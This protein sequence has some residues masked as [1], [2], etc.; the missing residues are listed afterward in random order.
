M[1]IDFFTRSLD[2]GAKNP[3]SFLQT[4]T[5]GR[6]QVWGTFW[7]DFGMKRCMSLQITGFQWMFLALAQSCA[8]KLCVKK[9]KDGQ[10]M[11]FSGKNLQMLDLSYLRQYIVEPY[12]G[13][14]KWGYPQIIHFHRIF[15]YKP[16]SCWGTPMT[17][18]TPIS[19][20][21]DCK[22]IVKLPTS[23]CRR[24]KWSANVNPLFVYTWMIWLV[25]PVIRM[26]IYCECINY[27][28]MYVM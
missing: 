14:L 4:K 9:H 18:E 3:W 27:V 10:P 15:H 16:S 11:F 28:C 24:T 25:H 7:T 21:I 1:I 13:F 5:F 23:P 8:W 17:W 26:W 19:I 22:V 20:W 12:G 2:L 6:D